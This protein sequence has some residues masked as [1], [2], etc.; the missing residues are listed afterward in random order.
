MKKLI[1]AVAL[2]ALAGPALA[3]HADVSPLYH[4]VTSNVATLGAGETR[5]AAEFNHAPLYVTVKGAQDR[6]AGED[7]IRVAGFDYAP[8]YLAVTMGR[9]I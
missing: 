5:G 9:N 1:I 8:L 2:S 3:D 7:A 6:F 4:Q